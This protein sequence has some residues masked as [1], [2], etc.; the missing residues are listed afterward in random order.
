MISAVAATTPT[1]VIE[2]QDAVPPVGGGL[3]VERAAGGATRVERR[4]RERERPAGG[5]RRRRPPRQSVDRRRL[6]RRPPMTRDARSTTTTT[7]AAATRIAIANTTT[8][9]TRPRAGRPVVADLAGRRRGEADQATDDGDHQGDDQH[10]TLGGDA[11]RRARAPRADRR[12]S[13]SQARAAPASARR[14]RIGRGSMATAAADGRQRDRHQQQEEVVHQGAIG[15]IQAP[16]RPGRR[17]AARSVPTTSSMSG[18]TARGP[19]RRRS[20]TQGSPARHR[21]EAYRAVSRRSGA[22]AQ[23]QAAGPGPATGAGVGVSGRVATGP[24]VNSISP[25]AL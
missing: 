20:R 19:R 5:S 23:G 24:N 9:P 18:G 10:E 13:T 3:R 4:D 25:H 15:D 8:A 6:G 7:A 16:A 17:R 21:S 14:S 12:G 1:S 2:Q 11:R 22:R